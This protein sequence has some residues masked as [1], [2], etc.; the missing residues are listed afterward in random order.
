MQYLIVLSRNVGAFSFIM[1]QRVKI[2]RTLVYTMQKAYY[3]WCLFN[4]FLPQSEL[5]ATIKKQDVNVL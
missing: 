4:V 1:L 2:E 5:A 3:V